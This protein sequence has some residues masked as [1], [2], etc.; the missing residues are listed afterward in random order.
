MEPSAT[1]L[2]APDAQ[3]ITS[4]DIEKMVQELFES[5]LGMPVSRSEPQN[6]EL[7]SGGLCGQIKISGAW[8]AALDVVATEKFCETVSC[9]MFCSE[10][11]SLDPADITDAMGEVTNVVGGNVKG[12]IDQ[13]CDLSIP[14]VKPFEPSD[15]DTEPNYWFQCS[16]EYF[17]VK[18]IVD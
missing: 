18:L 1:N 3:G 17:C 2:S 7:F 10:P 4:E 5:M 14:E 8:G 11:D 13:D 12:I 9:N 16:D 15:L 6:V